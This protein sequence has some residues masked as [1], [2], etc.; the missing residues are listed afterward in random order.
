MKTDNLKY[1]IMPLKKKNSIEI[2]N[3]FFF[4]PQIVDLQSVK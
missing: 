4:Y 2:M 3:L 1:K